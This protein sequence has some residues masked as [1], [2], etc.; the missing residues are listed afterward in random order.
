MIPGQP[1]VQSL[2]MSRHPSAIAHRFACSRWLTTFLVVTLAAV[3]AHAQG[4][5]ESSRW[6]PSFA[7]DFDFLGQKGRGSVETGPVLGPPLSPFDRDEDLLAPGSGCVN[8]TQPPVTAPPGTPPIYTRDGSLCATS[9]PTPAIIQ[10]FSS[11]SDTSIVPVVGASFGLMSP[12]LLGDRLLRPRLFVHGDVSSGFSYERNLAGTG[13]PGRFAVPSDSNP[14]ENNLEELSVKGQG[15]RTRMQVDRWLFS[16]G[17]G[18]AFSGEIFQR[19]FRIKP[20]VEYLREKVEYI[21]VVHRA[22]KRIR[23]SGINDL[24]RFRLIALSDSTERSYDGV[25]PGLELEV[26]AA[27]LGPFVSSVFLFGRGYYLFGD[28]DIQM[29]ATNE[30]GESAT[31]T[32]ELDRWAWRS[33]VGFRIRWS[34]ED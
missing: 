21:G 2:P 25:G 1:L 13:S 4:R 32:A 9:N 17:V 20:S 31:W 16:G 7:L 23:P 30:F 14:A 18:V 28:F 5:D 6:E 24:N 8:E 19:R 29:S 27:R 22:V 15:S 34:P 3:G 10:P 33:G 11:S 26:D 12:S